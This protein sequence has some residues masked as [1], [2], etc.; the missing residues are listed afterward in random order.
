MTSS[1]QY[2]HRRDWI[3]RVLQSLGGT[4]IALQLRGQQ[5]AD[6]ENVAA[7]RPVFLTAA[8]NDTLLSLGEGIVP[9]SAAAGC[10]RVIDLIVSIEGD[11]P[12]QQL[13]DALKKFEKRA[14][15]SHRMR[16]GELSPEQQDELLLTAS[17]ENGSLNAEFHLLKEWVSDAYWSS[18]AG[19]RELGWTG[20]MAWTEFEGCA[21]GGSHS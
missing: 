16:F 7:W 3:A 4:A 13:A 15:D 21:H 11:G 1:S 5:H 20:R 17:A 19:M 14:Q 8:Q 9:G 18:Q 10:N 2:L 6:Q 12:K